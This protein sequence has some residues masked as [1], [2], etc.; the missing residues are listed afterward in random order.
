MRKSYNL[1]DPLCVYPGSY[2]VS[3]LTYTQHYTNP[4]TYTTPHCSV[5]GGDM[6][7]GWEGIHLYV[8]ANGGQKVPVISTVNWNPWTSATITNIVECKPPGSIPW[9]AWPQEKRD[10]AVQLLNSSDWQSL[11]SS[12]PLGDFLERKDTVNSPIIVIPGQQTD[13]PNTPEDERQPKK[14][15]GSYTYPGDLTAPS[16]G[17]PVLTPEQKTALREQPNF[18]RYARN[19][20]KDDNTGCIAA[21]VSGHLGTAQDAPAARYATQVS[22]SPDDYFVMTPNGVGTAFDGLT[23]N[24]RNVWEAKY[25]YYSFFFEYN[26]RITDAARSEQ[27]IKWDGQKNTQIEVSSECGYNLTWAFSDLDVADLARDRWTNFPP[28]PLIIYNE[29]FGN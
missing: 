19:A 1:S 18:G 27:L 6:S 4:S 8:F 3:V 10:A 20:T 23:P 9:K 25:G 7:T 17:S 15:P 5:P 22:S 11:I 14:I 2:T 28:K 29:Y 12:M 13:N 21:P 26:P 16:S 24:T